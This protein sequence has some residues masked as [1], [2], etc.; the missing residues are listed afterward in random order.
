MLAFE[1]RQQKQTPVP[2]NLACFLQGLTACS[3]LEQ[4]PLCRDKK[5][6]QRY[7]ESGVEE[8]LEVGLPIQRL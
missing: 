2:A 7:L 1:I 6:Q 3:V 4:S 8:I 5:G